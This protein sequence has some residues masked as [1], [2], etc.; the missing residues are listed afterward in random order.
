VNT[1]RQGLKQIAKKL[2]LFKGYHV[3]LEYAKL[4]L[5]FAFQEY[6]EVSRKLTSG[7]TNF[8][9]AYLMPYKKKERLGTNLVAGSNMIFLDEIICC[10]A[11]G[12]NEG[13]TAKVIRALYGLPVAGA[14]F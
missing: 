6:C 8:S 7:E 5:Q 13:K 2:H 10:P 4:K 1:S 12:N 9:K 11:F 14:A 3:D